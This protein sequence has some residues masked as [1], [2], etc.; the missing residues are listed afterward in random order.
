MANRRLVIAVILAGVSIAQANATVHLVPGSEGPYTPGDTVTITINLENSDD[1]TRLLRGVQFDFSQTSPAISLGSTLAWN[2]DP[3]YGGIA[4]GL[5]PVPNWASLA[6]DDSDP[7]LL[8][9]LPP[10][11]EGEPVEMLT[12]GSLDVVVNDSGWVDAFHTDWDFDIN[13]GARITHGFGG[14]DPVTE[15]FAY[16][17]DDNPPELLGG[18]VYL[19]VPEP[20]SLV[21]LSV[22]LLGALQR[23][24]S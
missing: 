3:P 19:E 20:S 7:S 14:D 12:V 2:V 21:L 4:N 8:F 9:V 5:L 23:R 22:G 10:A 18:R 15:W 11:V 17:R 24:R 1:T 6:V 16:G 13:Q